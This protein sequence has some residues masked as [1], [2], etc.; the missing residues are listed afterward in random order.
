LDANTGAII[1]QAILNME[2]R[3]AARHNEHGPLAALFIPRSRTGRRDFCD[4]REIII[5]QLA[6]ADDE[7]AA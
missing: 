4:L 5:A 6:L 2:R 3:V 1:A 7:F